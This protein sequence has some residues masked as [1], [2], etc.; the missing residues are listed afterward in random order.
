MVLTV[1]ITAVADKDMKPTIE[2][3]QLLWICLILNP[4]A[5]LA[6][7]TNSSAIKVLDRKPEF[8]PSLITS[9]VV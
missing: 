7:V 8:K 4:V 3:S 1:V 2:A 6:L 9:N 5:A